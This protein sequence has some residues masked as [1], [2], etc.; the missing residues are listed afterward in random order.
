MIYLLLAIF[1]STCLLLVFKIIQGKNIDKLPVIVVNYGMCCVLGV[2]TS[3]VSISISE[4][5][6]KEWFPMSIMLGTLFITVFYMVAVSTQLNGVAVTAVAFKLSVVIPVAA[7]FYL[8]NDQVTAMKLA[9]IFT[10]TAAI[11]LT[12]YD[13]KESDLAKKKSAVLLPGI[14]FVGSGISDAFFNYIQAGYLADEDYSIFLMT[15]FFT[16]GIIG[17]AILLYNVNQKKMRMNTGAWVAGALLGIPNFGSAYFMILALEKSGI[18]SSALWPLNNIGI[19]LV[20]TLIAAMFFKERLNKFG[21]AGILAAVISILMLGF[22]TY[23]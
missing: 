12:S 5:M 22:A 23:G 19:I 4:I 8:Y 15:L 14:V 3:P 18:E 10:A 13:G 9:G 7:A 11:V 17:L 21:I 6:A 20:S 1:C 2:L 16:S